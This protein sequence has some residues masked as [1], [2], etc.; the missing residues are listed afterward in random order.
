MKRF[1][2]SEEEETNER[3]GFAFSRLLPLTSVFLQ[4]AVFRGILRAQVSELV[5]QECRL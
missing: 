2:L 5:G 4:G 1:H 3:R